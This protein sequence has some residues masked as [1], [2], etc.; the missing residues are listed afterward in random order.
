KE[1]A[2]KRGIEV[3]VYMIIYELTDEIKSAL[4]GMLAPKIKRTFLGRAKVLRIF[5][6]S[7]SGVIAG[8]VVQKGKI[9][10][11]AFGELIREDQVVTKG[12]V[13]S[14]KRFKDDV[15]EVIEAAECGIGID[16]NDIKEGDYIDVFTEEKIDRKL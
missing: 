14:L 1:F 3:R 4:E 2:R 5:K 7:R 6:L 12:K 11:G 8:C 16:Y 13:T 15:R 10:R 9:V